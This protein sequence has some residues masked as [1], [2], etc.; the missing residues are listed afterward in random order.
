MESAQKMVSFWLSQARAPISGEAVKSK[1]R[2]LSKASWSDCRGLVRISV[3]TEKIMTGLGSACN[4]KKS[5]IPILLPLSLLLLHVSIE[6]ETPVM[7]NTPI[8]RVR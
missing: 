2:E 8:Y 6:I 7:T 4:R 1:G 5:K 3:V